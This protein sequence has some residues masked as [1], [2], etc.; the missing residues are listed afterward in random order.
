MLIKKYLS[1]IL[2]KISIR[3]VVAISCIVLAI[4]LLVLTLYKTDYFTIYSNDYS[5]IEREYDWYIPQGYDHNCTVFSGLMAAKWA[6]HSINRTAADLREEFSPDITEGGWF[7]GILSRFLNSYDINHRIKYIIT[8]NKLI[9]QLSNGNIVIIHINPTFI[10]RSNDEESDYG[11]YYEPFFTNHVVVVK[12]YKTGDDG[13]IYFEVYDPWYSDLTN[14]DGSYKGKNRYYLSDE[15][16]K[17]VNVNR[18]VV[19]LNPKS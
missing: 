13:K 14:T 9:N 8:K 19:V 16:I 2:P 4:L 1:R 10:A 7:P 12:G 11:L 6:G 17:A 5:S 18:Y 3:K 15:L